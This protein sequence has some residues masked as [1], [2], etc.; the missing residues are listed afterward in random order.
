MHQIR[1]P[2]EFCPRPQVVP[3]SLAVFK[4]PTSKGKEGNWRKG[5]E[6]VND[7]K[8]SGGR[9]RDLAH[10]AIWRDAPINDTIGYIVSI[11][12]AGSGIYHGCNLTAGR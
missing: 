12:V 3:G 6:K 4:G 7:W 1:F 8:G 10:P 11:T 2:L 5:E 9:V